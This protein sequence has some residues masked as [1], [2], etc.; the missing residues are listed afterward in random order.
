MTKKLLTVFCVFLALVMVVL[1]ITNPLESTGDSETLQF[2]GRFHPVVLHLP[3]GFFIVLGVLEFLSLVPG[4]KNLRAST[5]IVLTL[6]IIGTL[7]AVTT[8]IVLAYGSGSNEPLVVYHMRVSLLLGIFSLGLGLLKLH[9]KHLVT[10]FAYHLVLLITFGLLFVASHHGGSITHGE[11]YLTKYMPDSLRPL[12][13]LEVEEEIIVASANELVLYRDVVHH[14]FEQNCNTCHNPNKKKGELNMETYEGLLKGGDT[15]YSIAQGDRDD[16]ELYFRITLPH[17]DDDFMPTDGKPP[18]SDTEVELIGWWIDQGADPVLTVADHGD[19]PP[20]ISDYIQKLFES[21]VSEEELE[22]REELRKELYAHLSALHE[23]LGIVIIPSAPNA[24]NF[25]VETFAVQKDFTDKFLEEL[26][27]F[28]DHIVEA[29]FSNT[30]LTDQSFETLAQFN[31]LRSLNLSKTGI[32]GENLG[33]LAQLSHLES[34]NLYG[35]DLTTD[36]IDELAQLTQLK[37]L[38]LFQT[39]LY[40]ADTINRL[41]QALPNCDFAFN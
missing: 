17:D 34:L 33:K 28:A 7:V 23:K 15:G 1:F 20:A 12:F 4:L 36:Q 21:M 37:N 26:K 39:D 30:Q 11:D 6:C 38:Y 31:N 24:T 18:L 27:P 35:T 41:K 9:G 8:G 25:K 3:I 5:P 14:I 10:R 32:R 22:A 2:F 13:G 40:E 16:S 29:D 19:I